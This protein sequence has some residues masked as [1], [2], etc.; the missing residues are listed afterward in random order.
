VTFLSTISFA[1]AD[2]KLMSSSLRDGKKRARPALIISLAALLLVL[3][4]ACKSQ[5]ISSTSGGLPGSGSS[6]PGSAAGEVS[7]TPPFQTKEPERYQ[8]QLVLKFSLDEHQEFS[9]TFIARDGI[10]R[11]EDYEPLPNVKVSDLQ[12]T[13]GH[14]LLLH[15]AKLYA[16]LTPETGGSVP[17]PLLSLPEDFAPDRLVNE[18]R[19]ETRYEKLGVEELNGR[20]ATKY[21]VSVVSAPGENDGT[22]VEQAEQLIWIDEQLGMPVRSETAL[23]DTGSSKTKYTMEMLDIKE[24]VDGSAFT[25]PQD[26][27][28]VTMKEMLSHMS[29]DKNG[30]K[31]QGKD[32]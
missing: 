11:R 12:T 19:T 31:P 10:K 6:S 13:E 15:D 3:N 22:Q 28:K 26:Y 18:S 29:G 23:K 21:R 30:A 4:A 5:G 24:E 8:A 7:A 17:G 14:F 20:S 16:E 25:V 9:Q 27:K 2:G 32:D 1:K